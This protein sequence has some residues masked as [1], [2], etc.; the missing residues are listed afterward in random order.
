MYIPQPCVRFNGDPPLKRYYIPRLF[1][2]K[3]MNGNM[4]TLDS[5]FF[6][7]NIANWRNYPTV[8]KS[9]VLALIFEGKI[10]YT[11]DH[12]SV[13]GQKG[14]LL[15]IPR[16]TLRA[17]ENVEGPHKKI[18]VLFQY[19]KKDPLESSFLG[20][21]RFSKCK[22]RNFEYIR[23]RFEK[24]YLETV[25]DSP[26][27]EQVAQGILL[28]LTGL[29]ARE[30]EQAEVA[31]MKLRLSLQLQNYLLDHYREP[32]Q[33]EQLATH[34]NRSAN[35]TTTLF[36][37]VTGM[38]PIQYIHQLRIKEACNLLNH[39]DLSITE[40]AEYLGYYDH[41]Y[42]FRTFKKLISLSPSDYRM[43]GFNKLAT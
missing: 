31:P 19:E 41:S 4:L 34:I 37:E 16:G 32:I 1:N 14:E 39:T 15:Y 30:L 13:I 12:H 25:G 9:N 22:I 38:S 40:I 42:F 2:R 7:N 10:R 17:S 6:D 5:V 43:A 35:Y 11:I 21:S 18:T 27:Q 33:I 23:H 3:R 28:E 29:I 24:L 26:Y 20:K 8:L 36:R